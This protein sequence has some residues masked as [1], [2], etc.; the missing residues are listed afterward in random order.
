MFCRWLRQNLDLTLLGGVNL[1]TFFAGGDEHGTGIRPS[2]CTPGVGIG[3]GGLGL[4][5]GF[6]QSGLVVAL[7]AIF[8]GRYCNIA[9]G[10]LIGAGILV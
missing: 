1:G 8:Y 6:S 7:L 5:L 4:G 9:V 10:V 2:I 3:V